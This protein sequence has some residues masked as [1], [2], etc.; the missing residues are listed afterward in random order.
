MRSIW[1]EYGGSKGKAGNESGV[2]SVREIWPDCCILALS[3]QSIVTR[4]IIPS[5]SRDA[6]CYVTSRVRGHTRPRCWAIVPFPP[7]SNSLDGL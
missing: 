7:A 5:R 1:I 2:G 4:Q 3:L 6:T